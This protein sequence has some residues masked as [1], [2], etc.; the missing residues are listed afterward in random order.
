MRNQRGPPSSSPS[1]TA[2]SAPMEAAGRAACRAPPRAGSPLGVAAE[3]C[4]SAG[5]LDSCCAEGPRSTVR[6]SNSCRSI[7]RTSAVKPPA[8]PFTATTRSPSRTR[9]VDCCS[10]FQASRAPLGTSRVMSSPPSAQRSTE[11]PR[12]SSD[13]PG[14]FSRT[15]RLGCRLASTT[16]GCRLG[17]SLLLGAA[18]GVAAAAAGTWPLASLCDSARWPLPCCTSLCRSPASTATSSTSCLLSALIMA[19]ESPRTPFTPTTR[20]P[21]STC[22]PGF[23]A[24]QAPKMPSGRIQSIRSVLPSEWSTCTPTALS[25]FRAFRS[26]TTNSAPPAIADRA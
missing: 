4:L 1:L 10:R 24:F 12:E 7:S 13:L 14:L 25:D 21:T 22:L 19:G 8:L 5:D 16:M 2:S 6:S 15:E 26:R 20:S 3:A 17:A 11:R 18:E 9:A 23:A